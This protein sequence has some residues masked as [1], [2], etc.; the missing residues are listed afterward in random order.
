MPCDHFTAT[1]WFRRFHKPTNQSSYGKPAWVTIK[2]LSP[3][4]HC[5]CCLLIPTHCLS[6]LVQESSPFP[7]PT[8]VDPSFWNPWVMRPTHQDQVFRCSAPRITQTHQNLLC[9]AKQES[10]YVGGGWGTG[11]SEA[12]RLEHLPGVHIINRPSSRKGTW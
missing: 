10:V 4:T 11:T 7:Q 8:E 9:C 12:K 3:Q 2:G 1:A 6:M 5:S